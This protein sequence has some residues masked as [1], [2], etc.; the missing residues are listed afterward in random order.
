MKSP[1]FSILIFALLIM[2]LPHPGYAQSMK[3]KDSLK[4]NK[5]IVPDI[6][7]REA[8]IALAHYPELKDTPIEFKFKKD[9]QKSFMQAQPKISGLFKNK[10]KRAYFVMISEEIVIEDE[11]FDVTAVPSD[12]LIGWLGHE[13]GHIMDYRERSGLNMLWFGM[14]YFASKTY[15]QEAERVA[16]T[17]AVNHGMGKYIIA[18]KDFILNHAHL[19]DVYKA[20]IK[21][22]YLS[23]GEIMMLI[24]ELE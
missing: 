5:K 4:F 6:I 19:S 24:D 20:R 10:K 2:G 23:Q 21:N 11:V 7:W 12:V 3:Q 17:Y 15:I 8:Y 13:L 16:D 9:I 14:K 18:T 1:V 22:L